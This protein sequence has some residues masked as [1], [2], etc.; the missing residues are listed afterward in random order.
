MIRYQ[1][2]LTLH[3]RVWADGSLTWDADLDITCNG[4]QA[5][6]RAAEPRL[7]TAAVH[8]VAQFANQEADDHTAGEIQP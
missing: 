6:L 1:L 7:T 4:R 5:D 2:I 8:A 3:A